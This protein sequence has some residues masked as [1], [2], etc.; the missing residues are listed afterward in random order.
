MSIIAERVRADGLR[1][2][3][4]LQLRLAGAFAQ[5]TGEPL[6]E[7][8][9]RLTNLHRRFGLGTIGDATPTPV[10]LDYC[11]GLEVH[12]DPSARL[13]WTMQAFAAAPG[14]GTSA[15]PRFGCFS[16]DP[17][18]SDGVLR[19]HFEN[20]D[21][22]DVSPLHADKLGRRLAD[23][24]RMFAHVVQTHPDAVT[25]RGS[26]WLYNLEAYRRL[27]PPDYG[28]SRRRV[29]PLRLNGTSSWGQLLDHRGAVKPAVREAFLANL[30]ALDP[31][32][33]WRV[34]PLPALAV[35]APLALFTAFYRDQPADL[36]S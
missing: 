20:R 24:A 33:P 6:G 36:L 30:P 31:Q 17:P 35:S 34:F 16:Y 27:F 3:F 11:R 2:Y 18:D 4:D 28:A 10:W 22:D 13:D 26:S 12:A 15:K 21:L 32:A 23:A 5:R 8:V 25:V 9:G 14:S 7:V 1:D 19:I 29:E